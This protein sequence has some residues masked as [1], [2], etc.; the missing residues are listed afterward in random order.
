MA[1]RDC[2]NDVITLCS[3]WGSKRTIVTKESTKHSVPGHKSTVPRNPYLEERPL[4]EVKSL[5][6]DLHADALISLRKDRMPGSLYL[7]MKKCK[8]R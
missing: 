2:F 7:K 1:E 8:F 3:S 5:I 4:N 6:R